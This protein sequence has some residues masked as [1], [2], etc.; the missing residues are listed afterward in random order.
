MV[1]SYDPEARYLPSGEKLI[2]VTSSECPFRVCN[3]FPEDT[4]D[5]ISPSSEP[6]AKCLPSGE[7]ATEVIKLAR[8]CPFRVLNSLPEATSQSS[9]IPNGDPDGELILTNSDDGNIKVW[10]AGSGELLYSRLQLSNNNWLVYDD[11]YH[12]DG[13]AAARDLL[14]FV[15][16]LEVIELN[17]VKD[18]LYVPGLVEKIMAG[19]SLA[20]FPK[21]S[22]L[23]ICGV[24]PFIEEIP[25]NTPN[26]YRYR[27]T[28]RKGGLSAVEVYINDKRTFTFQPEELIQQDTVYELVLSQEQLRP[29]LI[30]GVDNPIRVVGLTLPT[31]EGG[32]LKSR[33]VIAVVNDKSTRQIPNL[34]AVMVGVSDY[35]DDDL[36]LNYSTKDATDLS[37]VLSLSARKLLNEQAGEEH[38][39]V[40]N[41]VSGKPNAEPLRENI[42][43]TLAE[44]GKQSKAEDIVLLFFAGHGVMRGTEQKEFTLLT[45]EASQYNQIG[46]ST[47][48]LQEWLSPTGPHK[49]LAQKR[50]LI[51]DACNSGQANKDLLVLAR[52]DDETRRLRQIEDLKDKSGVFILSASAPDQNAYEFPQFE[53]GLLTYALLKTLKQNPEVLEAGNFLNV[54]RW[55]GTVETEVRNLTRELGR[56]QDAQ[57]FG[58]GNINIGMVDDEVRAAIHL[59]REKPVIASANF[60]DATTG[61]PNFALT[62]LI[63]NQLSQIATRGMESSI[64]FMASNESGYIIYGI[65]TEQAGNLS[66]KVNILKSGIQYILLILQETL[67]N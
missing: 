65:T 48:D 64:T 31:R 50:I 43:N 56:E 55:F 46:I 25:S 34:Y 38:V 63:N 53:Q 36:D 51:F 28:P 7:K 42:K 19:D 47:R 5:T 52:N 6:K 32:T 3:K 30:N 16:G 13:T 4:S 49:L 8:I 39:F 62:K 23:D 54:S 60:T 27:I 12:Y 35:K 40:Y 37:Q 15:C 1:L 61:L 2:E 58:S 44:I 66:C 9:M 26:Q 14:Y 41:L 17:Q 11:D 59:A 20:G 21:L 67:T 33:G 29:F 10:S 57:P 22:D 18:Q 45:A 24:T